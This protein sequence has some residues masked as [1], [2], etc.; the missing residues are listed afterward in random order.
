ME[1]L[2]SRR[3]FGV[4]WNGRKLQHFIQIETKGLKVIQ[5]N[6]HIYLINNTSSLNISKRIISGGKSGF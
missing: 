5:T 3:L 1:S 4:P 2:V 6:N